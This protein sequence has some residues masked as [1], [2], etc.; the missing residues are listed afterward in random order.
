LLDGTDALGARLSLIERAESS[1]DAQYFLMKDDTAGRIFSGALLRAA[2]RG[3]RIRLLLDDVFTTTDDEGLAVLDAHPNIEVRLFNPV[4]SRG[5]FFYLSFLTEFKR[6]NRRMHNKSFTVDNGISIVGGRNIAD[7]YFSIR[8][9]GEF[10]DF[11]VICAGD[12]A[13]A[14]SATFDTFW[15]DRLSVPLTFVTGSPETDEIEATRARINA[16]FREAD[17]S[18]Y[19]AAVNS[20]LISKLWDGQVS[21]FPAEY[22]VVTD[23]PEKLENV[24]AESHQTLVNHLVELAEDAASEIVIFTPY[25]VPLD[26]G[27][28]F[29]RDVVARGVRVMVVTNSLA[30][31]NHIAVHSAYAKY[32][33]ALVQA[34]VE[35][36]EVRAYDG[37]SPGNYSEPV[38]LHTKAVIVDRETLF[39]GSLNLDPRS[40]EI[41]A[42]MGIEIRSRDLAG[43][44]TELALDFIEGDTY[45]VTLSGDGRLHWTATV[46]GIETVEDSEP[47]SSGGRR[48]KAFVLKVVPDRQL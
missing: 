30:S 42:E 16:S 17:R 35:V 32:R 10:L 47:Q 15:N 26:D 28:D 38:T 48:F 31:T 41:N 1:I 5:A 23:D 9:A 45:R 36:Y 37:S 19:A 8:K 29:W 21:V 12:A 6:A 46:N 27:V 25:F 14:V 40:I 34:G 13:A 33:A 11:D 39:V 43:K 2:D 24:V 4:A 20:S 44:M 3:V 18:I 22:Q 7:E